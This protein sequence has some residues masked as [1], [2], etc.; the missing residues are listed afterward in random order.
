[1]LQC[2]RIHHKQSA[3]IFRLRAYNQNGIR[4]YSL[5]IFTQNARRIESS[6]ESLVFK[7]SIHSTG[8]AGNSALPQERSQYE[9]NTLP[10][11]ARV[12]ICGGGI[13]GGKWLSKFDADINIY[14]VFV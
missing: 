5:T 6:A 8:L 14:L 10:K 11:N 1:M 4:N 2:L 9:S 3:K 13:M 7:R 12:V